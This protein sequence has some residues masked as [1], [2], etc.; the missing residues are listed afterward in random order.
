MET[1]LVGARTGSQ[2][3]RPSCVARRLLRSSQRP[4]ERGGCSLQRG[5][6]F[7]T[8]WRV[9]PGG[10]I[11]PGDQR[12]ALVAPAGAISAPSKDP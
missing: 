7:L 3:A 4:D 11:V 1:R 6:I 9:P 8:E 5:A 12:Y 2:V 10:V